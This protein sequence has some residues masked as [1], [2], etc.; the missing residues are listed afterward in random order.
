[1]RILLTGASSF[2]GLAFTKALAAAGHQLFCPLRR[3]L[4][5]YT[6]L[7][8]QRVRQLQ[9]LASVIPS[10]SFGSP[11]FLELLAKSGPW[12]LLCHHAAEVTDYKNPSFDALA[13]LANNVK[14]LTAVLAG[15]Q[16]NGGKAIVLTGTIFEPDE[17]RG[18]E[19]LRAFSPYGLSKGLTWQV[20]RFYCERI[21]LPLGKFVLPNPFGPWEEPRFTAYLI[22][23]W[24][25][26]KSASVN[27]PDYVRDNIHADLLASVYA[28]FVQEVASAR[29]GFLKANPSGYVETQGA[30]ASRVAREVHA[31]TGWPCSLDFP[32]QQDFSEPLVRTNL[33]PAAQSV[34]SWNESAAWDSFV[35]FYTATSIVSI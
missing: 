24:K 28:Q 12:D 4:T 31:R 11:E 32:S 15:F 1:M 30:F 35:R 9:P 6:G 18:E 5:H 16:E 23:T 3:A 20:F 13:A 27:T 2:T 19:P 33:Q 7:R 14:D 26:G 10:V 21:N 17:G 25:I 29:S 34:T 22:N 8:Q